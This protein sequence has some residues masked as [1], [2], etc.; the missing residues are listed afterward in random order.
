MMTDT[1]PQIAD[2]ETRNAGFGRRLGATL[3]DAVASLFVSLG[4][5]IVFGLALK[6]SIEDETM[7]GYVNQG[8]GTVVLLILTCWLEASKW[9]GTPGKMLLNLKVENAEG[10]RITFGKAVARYFAKIPAA[11]VL[12]IGYL[13][14]LWSPKRL[15]WYD[16]WTNTRVRHYPEL[17]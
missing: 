16:G 2:L 17:G 9:Q 14:M 4:L 11:L 6:S 1:L 13:A 5:T 3:I 8:L 15:T 10:G 12:L 7:L